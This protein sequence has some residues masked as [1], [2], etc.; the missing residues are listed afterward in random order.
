MSL[1]RAPFLVGGVYA[2]C[3]AVPILI[4]VGEILFTDHDPH[5]SQGPIESIVSIALVGH[6]ALALGLAIALSLARTPQR[7]VA[8]SITLAVLSVVTLVFFWSGA[9]GILGACA[10]WRAGL[11]RGGTPLIGPGRVAGLIGAFIACLNIVLT[12]GGFTLTFVGFG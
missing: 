11:T 10:A 9:P 5:A 3:L 2:V 4:F 7:A 1:P 6:V 12:I 8:G